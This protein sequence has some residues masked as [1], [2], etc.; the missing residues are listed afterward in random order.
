VLWARQIAPECPSWACF[1][2]ADPHKIP[3]DSNGNLTQK[4]EGSDNWGYEWNANNE[5][6]RV[7]KNSVEQARFS[8]DPRGRRVERVAGGVT[9]TYTYDRLSIL[10]EVRGA[11]TLRYVHGPGIDEP[12]AVDDGAALS[13]F[14]T[15]LLGSITKVTDAAGAIALTRQYDAWGN[16]EVG[17]SEPGYAYTGREWDPVIGLYYYRARFFDPRVGRFI[18]EDPIEFKGGLNFYSYVSNRPLNRVDPLGLAEMP[19]VTCNK[20]L[21]RGRGALAQLC[22]KDGQFAICVE[23]G[24]YR[25]M[26]AQY[27]SCLQAHEG[28]HAEQW[29]K[30]QGKAGTDQSIREECQAQLISL[31]CFLI[32]G[33]RVPGGSDAAA[34]HA[35]SV[36]LCQLRNYLR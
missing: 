22:C 1:R 14:H 10:R 24:Q 9:T 18:S 20:G 16:I 13:Y 21:Y 36:S 31:Q 8:Y 33:E 23:E 28:Y 4:V 7:T 6:T 32:T 3:I 27:A 35:A 26:S 19:I 34:E 25:S 5:L 15:D 2:A 11:T 29:R 17:A 12:L 30:R